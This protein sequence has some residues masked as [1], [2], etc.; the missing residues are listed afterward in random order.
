MGYIRE[1]KG[2]D[3]TVIPQTKANKEADKSVSDFIRK[4]KQKMQKKVSH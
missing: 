2:I 1:P 4:E 3:L